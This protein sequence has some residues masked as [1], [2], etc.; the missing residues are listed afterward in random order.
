MAKDITL[1]AVSI[2]SEATLQQVLDAF[3]A[4]H[5][6]HVTLQYVSWGEYRQEFTNIALHHPP[7]D[8]AIT[9]TTATSDLLAMNALR[10]FTKSEVAALG[11]ETSFLPSRWRAG[12]RPGDD[13]IWA[14]PFIVDPRILYYRRDLLAKAGIAEKGAFD[15]LEAMERTIKRLQAGGV[16]SPWF[17]ESDR[18]GMVHR[19]ASF[20]WA[21]GGHLFSL[22]GKQVFFH[23]KEALEGIRA[24]CR[25]LPYVNAKLLGQNGR[26]LILS[27]KIAVLI[28]NAFVLFRE[29]NAE[30][31]CTAVPGGSYIGGSDLFIWNHTHNEYAALELVRYLTRPDVAIR[32]LPESYYLPARVS[33]INALAARTDPYS[34]TIAQAIFNGRT[35]PCVPMI[36]LVEERLGNALLSIQQELV[37]NPK[38]DLE[39]LLQQRIVSLGKRT[40]LTLGS[41]P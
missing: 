1:N 8:V 18:Y 5:N 28:D 22:D 41:L 2:V 27:G 35:F 15:T 4:Q 7:A 6:I 21:C 13:H 17:T 30:I 24:Y 31:G 20:I 37:A 40:N 29:T 14:I 9:G 25:L 10:P 32:M 38:A 16:A 34:A 3:E 23:E 12:M 26:E 33:E 19:L 11:G 39:T 36:G